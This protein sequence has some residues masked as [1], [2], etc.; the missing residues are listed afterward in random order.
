[1]KK[2]LVFMLLF[3]LDYICFGRPLSVEPFP[4]PRST[5]NVKC[6]EILG[7]VS[8]LLGFIVVLKIAENKEHVNGPWK[9]SS[10]CRVRRGADPVLDSR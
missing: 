8:F 10:W 3:P 2:I 9:P 6:L 7:S 5:F 4:L 1:M